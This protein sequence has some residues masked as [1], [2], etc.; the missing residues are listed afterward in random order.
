MYQKKKIAVELQEDQLV[1]INQ[2]AYLSL[3]FVCDL[4]KKSKKFYYEWKRTKLSSVF[5]KVTLREDV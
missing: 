4:H 5:C 2:S 1:F 3:I